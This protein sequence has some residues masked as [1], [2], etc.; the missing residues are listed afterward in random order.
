MDENG[1]N[2]LSLFDGISGGRVALERAGLKI[3]KYYAS[4]IDKHAIAISRY[5]YPDTIQLG[6]INNWKSWKNEKGFPFNFQDID[7][8]I[9]G[10]P[11]TNLSRAG[12]GQGLEGSQSK[13]FY[14]FV[15][16]VNHVRDQ[17]L[18]FTEPIILL[19]NVK[20][21]KEWQDEM[22]KAIGLEP[23]MI[24]SALVSAQ[25]RQRLYW[26]NI[27]IKQPEDRGIKLRDII[28]PDVFPVAIHNIY[29]GF[30]EKEVRT[31]TGKSPTIRA[32]SG[33]GS[34]PSFIRTFAMNRNDGLIKELEKSMTVCASDW[35]GLN[36]NQD[37]NCVVDLKKLALSDAGLKYMNRK[38]ADG[39]THWDFAHHSDVDDEKSATVVSNWAKGV[40]Y[41][42]LRDTECVREFHPIEVERLQTYDDNYTEYGNY[43]GVVKEVSKTQRLRALGNSFTVEVISY[44]LSRLWYNK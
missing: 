30:G 32:N 12:N 31:F 27:S 15:D 4:E 6:D 23:V 2:V 14:T 39:R 33:G 11:C 5:N 36:R 34:I 16:I 3:N 44:I 42:V 41:N 17:Y 43:D 8:I 13:L 37:Q 10:S 28:L 26:S 22:S 35:R 7:I 18:P 25:R 20:M 19:E 21:K 24:D 40:P 38:V 1:R 9:A 29:G